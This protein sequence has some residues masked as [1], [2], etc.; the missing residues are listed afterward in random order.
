MGL[1]PTKVLKNASVQQLLSIE[2]LPFPFVI[3]TRIS[4]HAALDTVAY[5]PFSLRKGA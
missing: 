5:A 3:P 4:C 1:R 2:P